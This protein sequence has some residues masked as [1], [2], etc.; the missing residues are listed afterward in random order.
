MSKSDGDSH[1][2]KSYSKMHISDFSTEILDHILKYL[3]Q[4]PWHL[5][6]S[7]LVN[8]SWCAI[9][10]PILWRDPFGFVQFDKRDQQC[11]CLFDTY[12]KFF[13]KEAKKRI[14]E[15]TDLQLNT[16]SKI[17]SFFIAGKHPTFRYASFLKTL[18]DGRINEG[19]RSWIRN[20]LK[21]ND[22]DGL[23]ELFSREFSQL[24]FNESVIIQELIV[25]AEKQVF[26]L[27]FLNLAGSAGLLS[28]L[29]TLNL[30]WNMG[31]TFSTD[32]FTI[33]KSNCR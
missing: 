7:A 27:H 17:N 15:H 18:N 8:R 12:F 13:D 20:L 16:S 29:S 14:L 32:V 23:H 33:L 1:F 2:G 19:I 22:I 4:N 6:L 10:I 26:S 11:K 24:L 30:S 31:E 25:N 21:T 28:K 9:V 3:S 5:L